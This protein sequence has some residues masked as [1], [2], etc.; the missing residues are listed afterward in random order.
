M[1]MT[2][3]PPVLAHLHG[4]PIADRRARLPAELRRRFRGIVRRY[5]LHIE[6]VDLVLEDDDELD[7]RAQ[8]SPQMTLRPGAQRRWGVAQGAR[9]RDDGPAARVARDRDHVEPVLA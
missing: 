8:R 1:P 9:L 5:C 2:P 3:Q 6:R 7:R 4:E